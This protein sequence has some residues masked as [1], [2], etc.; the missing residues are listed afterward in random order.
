MSRDVYSALS[1]AL[2]AWRSLEQVA[3][4]LANTNTTAFKAERMAFEVDGPN[5]HPLGEAYA[6]ARPATRDT[7]DGAV[8]TDGVS[9]HLALQGDGYFVVG[10]GDAQ[11]LT[12]D[13]RFAVDAQ[14]RIVDASGLPVMGE[15]GPLEVPE[16]ETISIAQDGTVF[17]SAS[18]E[19]GKV[20]VVTAEVRAIGAN[21][22]TATGPLGR[23]DARMVQGALEASNV[24]PM[25]AM[26]E[27][28]Q[29]SRYFEAFQK[30]MQASD[31]LDSR[32]NQLGGR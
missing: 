15:G 29:A 19:L 30:A 18:G 14:R 32:L 10:T 8:V 2:G 9:T 21:R 23:S 17:G 25:G 16:G 13:G 11:V 3:N 28:V 31:E 4:N 22:F 6:K 24:D 7:R 5:A 26:V 27:L 20:K 1:G 12:R